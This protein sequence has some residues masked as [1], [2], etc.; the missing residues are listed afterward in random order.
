MSKKNNQVISIDKFNKIEELYY[1]RAN[2][3]YI[4]LDKDTMLDVYSIITKKH[5]RKK[6]ISLRFLDWFVTK[7]CKL[8]SISINVN[9]QYNKEDKY[10]INNRYKAQ[11]KSFHKIY[12]DPF[13][14]T[15]ESFKFIYKCCG[16]EFITSLC[17]LNFMKWIIEYDILKYVINNYE[18]L[19]EKVEYVN[20]LHKKNKNDEKESL[21]SFN[22]SSSL[23]VNLDNNKLS[24]KDNK[25][26]LILEI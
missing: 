11:L 19:I 10:N 4:N 8:Y 7:Y 3:F 2:D 23:T 22:S 16:Y 1:N 5:K 13:K 20:N 24:K 15:K 14:R 9:N 6:K 21:Y 17:Q 12:L 25:K 18:T 26:R